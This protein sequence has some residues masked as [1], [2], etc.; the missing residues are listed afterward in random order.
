MLDLLLPCKSQAI[1]LL[2]GQKITPTA[3]AQQQNAGLCFTQTGGHATHRMDK[4]H[5]HHHWDDYAA[6]RQQ[7]ERFQAGSNGY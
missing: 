3:T 2:Y 4:S 1:T 5:P 7:V 6:T